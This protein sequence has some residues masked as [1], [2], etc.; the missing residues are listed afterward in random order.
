MYCSLEIGSRDPKIFGLPTLST[1]RFG[2]SVEFGCSLMRSFLSLMNMIFTYD[3]FR[4]KPIHQFASKPSSFLIN[5][6]ARST[7]ITLC[8]IF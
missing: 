3:L 4:N 5:F 8:L 2:R 7:E 1:L 6:N